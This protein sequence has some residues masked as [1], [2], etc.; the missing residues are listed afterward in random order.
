MRPPEHLLKQLSVYTEEK[1]EDEEDFRERSLS[2]VQKPESSQHSKDASVSEDA[3]QN[4]IFLAKRHETVYSLIVDM[5]KRLTRV[6]E[7]H[8][9][10]WYALSGTRCIRFAINT[11]FSRDHITLFFRILDNLVRS[12]DGLGYSYV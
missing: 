8:D 6:L 12:A 10:H 9:D 2:R 11:Y 5:F 4:L 7:R 1:F 3:Y